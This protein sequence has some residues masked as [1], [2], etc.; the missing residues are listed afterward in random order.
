MVTTLAHLSQ[1][2]NRTVV[3]GWFS[4][5]KGQRI[6]ATNGIFDLLHPGHLTLLKFARQ[7]GAVLIV[8]LNSDI[9]TAALKPGRPIMPACDRAEVLAAVRWVDMV[10]IYD[11][12][13]ADK[14][15]RWI[16]PSVYVKGGDY[17]VETLDQAERA[18][19]QEVGSSIQF[20]ARSPHSTSQ[21]VARLSAVG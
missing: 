5:I 11:E 18:A 7:Q 3:A 19:L 21:L 6:V 15:L 1:F 20:I 4:T 8:G 12:I 14:F 13:R 9:S 17:T 2:P 10:V 16:R